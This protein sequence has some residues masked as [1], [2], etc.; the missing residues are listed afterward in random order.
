MLCAR[1]GVRRRRVFGVIAYSSPKNLGCHGRGYAI[2]QHS[3]LVA[4]NDSNSSQSACT[5]RQEAASIV[6]SIV[7]QDGLMCFCKYQVLC[8][9]PGICDCTGSCALKCPLSLVSAKTSPAPS[10]HRPS[11]QSASGLT[12]CAGDRS[13][14]VLDLAESSGLPAASLGSGML[15]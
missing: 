7:S 1:P 12:L 9:R 8:R 15:C 3:S 13:R 11:S 4:D 5:P 10:S 2:A 14:L 6:S